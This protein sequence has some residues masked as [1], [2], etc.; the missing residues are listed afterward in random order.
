MDNEDWR[1]IS[2]DA[3]RSHVALLTKKHQESVQ[4]NEEYETNIGIYTSR[5][6]YYAKNFTRQ[7]TNW[8]R[9][10]SNKIMLI[11]NELI[12]RQKEIHK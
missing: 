4:R 7:E 5:G 6:P 9:I 11:L 2:E 8:Q 3:L 10:L 1:N 12:R